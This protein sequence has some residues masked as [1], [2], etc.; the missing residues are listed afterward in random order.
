MSTILGILEVYNNFLNP[1]T[2]KIM[3]CKDNVDFPFSSFFH[4]FISS[5]YLTLELVRTIS[6]QFT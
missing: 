4:N 2:V 3:D 1:E 5:G 6:E